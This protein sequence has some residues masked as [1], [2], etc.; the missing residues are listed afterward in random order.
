MIQVA[1]ATATLVATTTVVS[2]QTRTTTIHDCA[3]A[4]SCPTLTSTGTVCCTCL[5]VGCV[6][7]QAVTDSCGCP[8][9]LATTAIDFP[10]DGRDSC[11]RVGC[12]T[13]YSVQ[14]RRCW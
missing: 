8:D 1:S 12:R 14:S 4:P 10:C 5:E 3:P 9:A 6:T 13:V 2:T 11:S 7:T